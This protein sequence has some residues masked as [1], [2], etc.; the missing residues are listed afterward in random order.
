MLPENNETQV[1]RPPQPNRYSPWTDEIN[2]RLREL[3][4]TGVSHSVI[5]TIL[6]ETF[7]TTF[8]RNACIGRASR[9]RLK[10]RDTCTVNFAIRAGLARYNAERKS[11]IK[12]APLHIRLQAL[13]ERYARQQEA[14]HKPV[15]V[16]VPITM[17]SECAYAV[18]SNPAGHHLFCN[19]RKVPGSSWCAYH[20]EVVFRRG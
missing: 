15:S 11:A 2:N 20:L 16:G 3:Y 17:L 12:A 6:N 14:R 1:A 19:H 5:A 4:E 10:P 9:M 8:S 7:G 18:A 13:R